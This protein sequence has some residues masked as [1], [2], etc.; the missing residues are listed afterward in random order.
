[1]RSRSTC[2][3]LVPAAAALPRPPRSGLSDL[4]VL[5][6]VAKVLN[7]SVATVRRRIRDGSLPAHRI[8]GRLYVKPEELRACVE[9]HA[10]VPVE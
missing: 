7:V 10:E 1:M 3:F 5:R 6:E 8:K 2:S 9:R 4:M